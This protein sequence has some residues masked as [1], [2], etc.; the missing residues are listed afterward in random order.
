MA[1]TGSGRGPI[2]VGSGYVD[3]FP[4]MNRE[5][6]RKFRAQVDRELGTVGKK[7][8]R[9]FTKAISSEVKGA[10]KPMLAEIKKVH[11]AST[12]A[13][14]DSKK[15]LHRIAKEITK[16]YGQEAGKRFLEE[17]KHEK[18]KR[19]LLDQ[20]TAATRSALRTI[21]SEEEKA[22]KQSAQRWERANKARIQADKER[23]L[24]AKAARKE[25]ERQA[26][27][28]A[29]ELIAYNKL[30]ERAYAENERRKRREAAE[31]ARQERALQRAWVADQR[32]QFSQVRDQIAADRR[33]ALRSLREQVDTQRTLIRQA[34]EE[35]R[36]YQ[37]QVD[38]ANRNQLSGMARVQ[39]AWDRQS[40]RIEALGTHAMEAGRMISTHLLAP[41]GAVASALSMIGIR[42]A[43]MRMLGQLGLKS[44]GVS[45]GAS[46]NALETLQR[47]AIDTPFSIDAMHEYQMKMIRTFAANDERWYEPQTRTKA[48]DKAA[49]KVTDLIMAI[50]DSMA[51]AGNLS[52]EMF[53]RALY[54]A[55]RMADMD[56]A[57]TRNLNQL[58]AATGVSAP[59]LATMFGFDSAKEFWTVV[60]TPVKDGGGIGGMD[61]MDNLLRY[62]DPN[63]FN[64]DGD[65]KGG[66]KGFAEMMT[67]ATITGRWDQI[68]ERSV[69]ELG[70]LFAREGEDGQYEYTALGE[71]L[72]G[73][74]T[75]EDKN[76]NAV[77]EGGLLQTVQTLAGDNQQNVKALLT[78]FFDGLRSVGDW[79][80][81]ISA[82]LNQHPEIKELLKNLVKA[83]VFAAPFL[84]AFG[85]LTKIFGK[86]GKLLSPMLKPLG[87]AL[88]VLKGL[89]RVG[90]QTAAGVASAVRGN[91]FRSGYRE[92]RGRYW[93][94]DRLR[95]QGPTE[96][97]R[98]ANRR[99]ADLTDAM[100]DLQRELRRVSRRNS[101]DEA[102][103]TVP[104]Q[105]P[106]SNRGD[107]SGG[108]NRPPSGGGSPSTGGSGNSVRDSE[109]LRDA[110]KEV[111]QAADN[112]QQAVSRLNSENLGTLKGE[113]DKVYGVADKLH[114]VIG[115]GTG[116]GD[117]AGRVDNLDRRTLGN[118]AGQFNKVETQARQAYNMVGQGT[119]GSNLAGRVGLLDQR[120]LTNIIREFNKLENAAEKAHKAVGTS[121]SN[122]LSGGL[123]DANNVS[124][125]KIK[126]AIDKLKKALDDAK[127]EA[128]KLE[129]N[130]DDISNK[131]G[132]GGG[133]NDGGKPTKKARGGL[134][135]TSDV[136][137]VIPGYKPG[138]DT[139][140]AV[141]SPGE[142]ILRPEVTRAIGE[143]T[144]N[145]W[146]YLARSGQ[147]S[148][149]Q[150]FK[151]G[152]VVG[153]QLDNIIQTVKDM[154]V[155]NVASGAAQNMEL[156]G[157]GAD[158]GGGPRGGIRSVAGGASQW[159]GGVAADKFTGIMDFAINDSWD[160][161]KRIPTGVG[162]VLGIVG[163]ALMPTLGQYF[164]DD[165][166]WGKGNILERGNTFLDHTFSTKT[167]SSVWDD[168][169]G[170][171]WDSITSIGS[172]LANPVDTVTGAFSGLWDLAV[173]DANSVT[174][175]V[176]AVK[177]IM[178]APKEHAREVFNDFMTTAKAAMPNTK[179][180]FNFDRDGKVNVKQPDFEKMFE[181]GG[182]GAA[183]ALGWARTQHGKP[184][185]WGGNGNP[186]WDC[187]GFLS[188]IESVMRG[189]SPHRRW[190]TG[191]FRG[192]AAPNG[193][194][195]NLKAPYMIGITNAGV[196][197]TA[198]TINGVN[199]ES[200]GGDGVVVGKGARSYKDPMFTDVYGF[201][202]SITA[203]YATGTRSASPGMALVAEKG[204]E[205]VTRP[206]V[207]NFRGGE[208]VYN[209]DETA[210]ILGGRPAPTIVI[211][212][213]K[214][215]TTPQ[216]VIRGLQ[217]YDALYGSRL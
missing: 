164:K 121:K 186:S 202:P 17:Q 173:A 170:G 5:A 163:G 102:N 24:Q 199:V 90:M 19:K 142:G 159:M 146:N 208:T 46:S 135:R 194:V 57:N 114:K 106:P 86:M 132:R 37:R 169:I 11:K 212:E 67:S 123:T 69:Y 34:Q 115:D 85:L 111:T 75:G 54:A 27:A 110:L 149:I 94:R 15:T 215:E 22:A 144:I 143:N 62:W 125:K 1:V 116:A 81:D 191:A 58:V 188:A 182:P 138:I 64:K 4:K 174:D 59:E 160:A 35:A 95:N 36:G 105:N 45:S 112:A 189:E 113:F 8:G 51:R 39:K 197:H 108:S 20:T 2:K 133:K 166:W 207:R 195:R 109:R 141:L 128:G 127:D 25:E 152:G 201:R 198:G 193:W 190:A 47:Y 120:R 63:Y 161:L 217:H 155:W 44:A 157:A 122:G 72:M 205:L 55:D 196:G 30:V 38:T 53:Q 171:L 209:A 14:K 136:A 96:E 70:N 184:Y 100:E 101:T 180:L 28:Q 210:A 130:L 139:V 150:K 18:K 124:Q 211:H 167:V 206:G 117:I 176:K 3:V 41:L 78:T 6:M 137:P 98:T 148:K 68:K 10:S 88:K 129:Q 91:G 107:S 119:G 79:L 49:G 187:S 214:S 77:Y 29:R 140:P 65:K 93:E 97:L 103:R 9:E 33:E 204:P 48:A 13:A 83:A 7:A 21:T 153:E 183:K 42:S 87:V 154:N 145:E 89:G 118:V 165:I 151:N 162:Q 73:R 156:L 131:T 179:D 134:I 177:D 52:P 104:R 12:D 80:L 32:R 158:I 50:G 74:K 172:M 26:A 60:G 92:R 175:S 126:D 192:T 147:V 185:Q 23:V 203:A 40:N 99:L 61:L 31:T 66:S 82:W 200:R 84:I 178:D 16:L 76:G 56:K 213:A 181:T 71:S 43:D 168:L 216:A